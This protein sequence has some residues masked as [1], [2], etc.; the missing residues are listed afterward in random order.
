MRYKVDLKTFMAECEANY[1][2]LC[3]LMPG[4]DV[5]DLH[6]LV[7]PGQ[8]EVLIK[9]R[10]RTA[11]TSLVE[12]SQVA[13]SEVNTWLKMPCLKVRLYHDAKLAEVVSF[14]G[15]RNVRPRNYYPNHH[16]HQPDEKAQWNHFLAEWLGIAIRYGLA[17]ASPCEFGAH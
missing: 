9:V 14:E 1:Y 17:V 16:M 13:D 5:K 7:L 3:K 2:C 8:G 12:I 10:E 4:Q 6:G 11:Y 15:S